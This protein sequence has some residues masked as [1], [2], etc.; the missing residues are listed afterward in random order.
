MDYEVL[1]IILGMALVTYLTRI[2]TLVGLTGKV[3]PFYLLTFLKFIPAAILA[4]LLAPEIFAPGGTL[5]LSLENPYLL[6]AIPSFVIALTAK[7]LVWTIVGGMAAMVV[8][9]RFFF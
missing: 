4:A 7:S 9:T 5:N 2:T 3:L 6:A 8:F 1:L